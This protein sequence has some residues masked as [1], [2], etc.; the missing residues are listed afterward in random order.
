MTRTVDRVPQRRPRAPQTD[1]EPRRL[2]SP[3]LDLT[4][5]TYLT[6]SH[7]VDYL[8]FSSKNAFYLWVQRHAIP[9]IRRGRS[10]TLLFRRKD[11]DAALVQPRRERVAHG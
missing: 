9:K 10:R 5:K 11:L 1:R 8:D 7:A 2:D 6:V 4:R 3:P